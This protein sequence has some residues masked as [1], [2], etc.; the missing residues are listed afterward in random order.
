[1]AERFYGSALKWTR[2][3]EANKKVIPNPDYIYIGQQITIP[4]TG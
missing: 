3:Y 2:I 1:L 4:A